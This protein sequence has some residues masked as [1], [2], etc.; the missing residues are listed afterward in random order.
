MLGER[1]FADRTLAWDAALETK[2]TALTP[3]AVNEAVKRHL[4]P[5][6]ITKVFA[7]DFTR[8]QAGAAAPPQAP[9]GGDQAAQ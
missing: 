2:L 4:Q 3:A 1:A 8:A 6:K 5:A 9:P 7:G